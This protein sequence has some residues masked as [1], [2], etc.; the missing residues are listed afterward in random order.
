MCAYRVYAALRLSAAQSRYLGR[1]VLIWPSPDVAVMPALI[2]MQDLKLTD[3]QDLPRATA[4]LTNIQA[5]DA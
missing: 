4:W 3:W 1:A 2:R 5:H